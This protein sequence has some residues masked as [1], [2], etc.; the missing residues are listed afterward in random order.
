MSEATIEQLRAG[1]TGAVGQRGAFTPP[2][3]GRYVN[4]IPIRGQIMP[5]ILLPK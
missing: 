1:G 5:T 4:S 2:D 3:F